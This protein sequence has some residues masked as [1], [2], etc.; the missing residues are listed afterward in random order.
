M[1]SPTTRLIGYRPPSTRGVTSST[2]ARRRPSAGAALPGAGAPD[3]VLS[4]AAGAAVAATAGPSDIGLVDKG[5]AC[6]R[7]GVGR[8]AEPA[9]G[10]GGA[11]GATPSKNMEQPLDAAG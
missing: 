2:T 7:I 4:G 3:G 8:V 9:M 5:R 6:L 1:R 11:L 10:Y